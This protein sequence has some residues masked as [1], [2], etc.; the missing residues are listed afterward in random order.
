MEVYWRSRQGET[1]LLAGLPHRKGMDG[2]GGRG[3]ELIVLL[4][5]LALMAPAARGTPVAPGAVVV[6]P[7]ANMYSAP[8]ED[9]DVVSQAIFG[10]SVV[11]LEEK[12]AW[13]K[14]RTPDDYH[15]WMLLAALHRYGPGD[16]EYAAS[17]TVAQVANPFANV[18]REPDVT[19]H[20][21]LLTLPFA[22]HLEVI[23][24]PESEDGRWI[25]VRLPEGRSAW[26]QRGDVDLDPRPLS[27]KQTIALAKRF[28]GFTYLGAELPASDTIV[29]ASRRCWFD[30]VAS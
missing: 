14:V 16:H 19:K 22:A 1:C 25:E 10:S 7:V 5:A 9:A 13:A 27:I 11:L 26:V 28:L 3:L 15:G 12:S 17:G 21:P 6:E 29:R 24:Q 8:S 23:S 30:S 20:Q 2:S 18:Y 4:L